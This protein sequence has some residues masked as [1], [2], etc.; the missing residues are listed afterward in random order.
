M[1]YPNRSVKMCDLDFIPVQTRDMNP[2]QSLGLFWLNKN[3]VFVRSSI[4]SSPLNSLLLAFNVLCEH[5]LVVSS[6]FIMH[7]VTVDLAGMKMAR[8]TL[9]GLVDKTIIL[10]LGM[11][12][13]NGYSLV[14]PMTMMLAH[15]LKC[16]KTH[17]TRGA[18]KCNLAKYLLSTAQIYK[19]VQSLTFSPPSLIFI[20]DRNVS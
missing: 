4:K 11:M 1:H 8:K 14:E 12:L 13:K 5:S 2:F 19:Q 20:H 17:V 6:H 3:R 7:R 15:C 16:S 18:I 9:D 10:C